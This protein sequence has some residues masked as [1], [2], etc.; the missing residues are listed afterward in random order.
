MKNLAK[1]IRKNGSKIIPKVKSVKRSS[2][3]HCLCG[4]HCRCS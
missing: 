2:G 4:S 3:S 1:K